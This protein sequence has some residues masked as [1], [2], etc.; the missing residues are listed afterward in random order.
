MGNSEALS[1]IAVVFNT[2]LYSSIV[3]NNVEEALR[4]P[5]WKKAMEEEISALNKNETW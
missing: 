2:S 1:Q 3:P 5:N 4:D